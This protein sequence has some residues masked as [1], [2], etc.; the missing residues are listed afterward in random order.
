MMLKETK[1]NKTDVHWCEI[2]YSIQKT[3][4]VIFNFQYKLVLTAIM[5]LDLHGF[6]GQSDLK[7]F[8]FC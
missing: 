3:V 6:L 1:K 4:F 7:I 8:F 5:S 2:H